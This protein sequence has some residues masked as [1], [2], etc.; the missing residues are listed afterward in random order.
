MTWNR[1]YRGMDK[2]LNCLLNLRK[3]IL[4]KSI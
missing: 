1:Q 4:A 2:T 3:S